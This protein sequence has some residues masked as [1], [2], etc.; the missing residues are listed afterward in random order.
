MEYKNDFA[1][2]LKFGPKTVNEL[3]QD[4]VIVG[5]TPLFLPVAA[6]LDSAQ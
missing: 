6:I 2:S 5:T 3:N 1:A 4:H